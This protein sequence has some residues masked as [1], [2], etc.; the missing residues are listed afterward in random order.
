MA[1]HEPCSERSLPLRSLPP[2]CEGTGRSKVFSSFEFA[3]TVRG[4]TAFSSSLALELSRPTSLP[5]DPVSTER[6]VTGLGL[7]FTAPMRTNVSVVHIV[8]RPAVY[9]VRLPPFPLSPLPFPPLP[10]SPPFATV[11]LVELELLV[12]VSPWSGLAAAWPA[13]VATKAKIVRAARLRRAVCRPFIFEVLCQNAVQLSA[14]PA[15]NLR[16]S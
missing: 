15:R 4:N 10:L 7:S 6:M 12:V 3:G 2:T 14:V 1:S 8:T 5:F 9:T 11:V 13:A 16:R